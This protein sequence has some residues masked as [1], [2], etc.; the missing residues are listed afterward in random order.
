MRRGFKRLPCGFSEKRAMHG[1]V[2]WARPDSNRRPSPCQGD[3]ITA[4]PRAQ[5]RGLSREPL[6]VFPTGGRISLLRCAP[7]SDSDGRPH[8]RQGARG[9]GPREKGDQ[10]RLELSRE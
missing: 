7:S 4:R 3:V 10:G 9:G 8:E 6:K 1:K 5:R 2:E